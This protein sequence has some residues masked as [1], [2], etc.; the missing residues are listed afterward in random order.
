MVNRINMLT[1]PGRLPRFLLAL[2]ALC[3]LAAATPSA[4]ADSRPSRVEPRAHVVRIDRSYIA[5]KSAP[6]SG[7]GVRSFHSPAESSSGIERFDIHW[8]ATPPGIPPGVVLLLETVPQQGAT[9]KNHTLRTDARSEGHVHSVMEIPSREI[10]LAGRIREWRLRL[11]FRGALLAQE[12]S[13]GW[14]G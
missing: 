9:V 1:A 12:T 13:P 14:E 5:P 10:R 2:A 8:Y 4:T 3:G 7:A 11:V 6:L